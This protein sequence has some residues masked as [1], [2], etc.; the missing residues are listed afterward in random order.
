MKPTYIQPQ[1]A[2]QSL[3]WERPVLSEH[4]DIETETHLVRDYGKPECVHCKKAYK[5]I[6]HR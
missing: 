3:E 1:C 4:P 5:V 6:D 2:C